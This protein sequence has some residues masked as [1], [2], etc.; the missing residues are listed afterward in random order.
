MGELKD[1]YGLGGVETKQDV[2][3]AIEN[4]VDAEMGDHGIYDD[5]G[6]VE[7]ALV[8]ALW[9]FL[10]RRDLVTRCEV[11]EQFY[12]T[13]LNPNG[14]PYVERYEHQPDEDDDEEEDDE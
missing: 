8:A 4:F 12:I 14:C 7:Y 9:E 1:T 10:A 11:C 3:Q 6:D 13:R 2:I 5:N